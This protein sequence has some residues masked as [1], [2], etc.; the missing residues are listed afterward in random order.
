VYESEEDE[1]RIG[2]CHIYLLLKTDSLQRKTAFCPVGPGLPH[3][4]YWQFALLR[5][6]DTSSHALFR[7]FR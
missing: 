7:S 2:D 1:R 3:V 6:K 5:A 4:V